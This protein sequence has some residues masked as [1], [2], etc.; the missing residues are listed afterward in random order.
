[1]SFY[2]PWEAHYPEEKKKKKKVLTAL[3]A[4]LKPHQSYLTLH[5]KIP[6]QLLSGDLLSLKNLSGYIW[7]KEEQI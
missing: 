7:Y 5:Y 3:P 4:G 1:M 2:L 6:Y